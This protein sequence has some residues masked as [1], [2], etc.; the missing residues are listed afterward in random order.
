M[1]VNLKSHDFFFWEENEI[2]PL[3]FTMLYMDF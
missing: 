1:F 2:Q 3:T